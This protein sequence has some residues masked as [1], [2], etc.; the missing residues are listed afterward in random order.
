M[1]ENNED[2]FEIF[3]QSGEALKKDESYNMIAFYL[4]EGTRNIRLI[5]DLNERKRYI[6]AQGTADISEKYFDALKT[7]PEKCHI[8]EWPAYMSEIDGKTT[9]FT[10]WKLIFVTEK[11]EY[12]VYEG[13]TDTHSKLPEGFYKLLEI[14]SEKD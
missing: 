5:C 4:N 3:N 6:E 2:M 14:L 7:I 10:A 11:E 9:G 13:Y 12:R 8:Y 1:T